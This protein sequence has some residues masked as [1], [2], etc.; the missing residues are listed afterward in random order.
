M[1]R[2]TLILLLAVRLAHADSAKL[3]DARAA[4]AHVHY[5]DAQ[6]LLAAALQ[7]GGNSP[8][9][10]CELY[11][12]SASTAIVLGHREVG[13]QY[14]RR[15]LALEPTATL[16]ADVSPKLRDA[17]DAARAYI[18]AHGALVVS[19]TRTP[20]GA[21]DVAVSSDP[22]A[23]VA[24]IASSSG[25]R[26]PVG[27]DHHAR[28]ASGDLVIALDALGNHLVELA[29]AAAPASTPAP[30][31]APHV[32][33]PAV[34]PALPPPPATPAERPIA[35]RWTTWAI[36]TVVALTGAAICLGFAIDQNSK[37]GHASAGDAPGIR[38]TRNALIW[39]SAISG[40]LAIGFGI[41]ATIFFFDT[42]GA[43]L[44]GANAP[45]AG[46]GLSY[47]GRF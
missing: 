35:R 33:S 8:R 39:G 46:A 20:G 31:P 38:S 26:V 37:L 15:W 3:G 24:A 29:P 41:P 30:L 43:K 47:V 16:S 18:T 21:I 12:L 1:G 17:F 23:M 34:S 27:P 13:E 19:A 4:I 28:L 22:L 6:R 42:P 25:E 44:P 36:P 10:V 11:E 2:I 7:E 45:G 5:D 9:A 40:A 14:Y 32:E